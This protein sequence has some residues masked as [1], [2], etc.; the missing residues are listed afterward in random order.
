MPAVSNIVES[1]TKAFAKDITKFLNDKRAAK[2]AVLKKEAAKAAKK[3]K[4]GAGSDKVNDPGAKLVT[5]TFV[6]STRKVTQNRSPEVQANLISNG[7][8]WTCASAHMIDM[9]RH[10]DLMYGAPGKKA[11]VSWALKEAFGS[12]EHHFVTLSEVKT[13]W[14]ALMK[15]HSLKNFAG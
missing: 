5:A 13:K 8:S 7:K 6:L 2:I 9:A 12:K 15:T 10:V 3:S 11:G 1:S 4:S 14:N